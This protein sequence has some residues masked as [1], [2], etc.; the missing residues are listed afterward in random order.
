SKAVCAFSNDFPNRREPG[1]LLI[2]IHDDGTPSGLTVSDRLLQTLGALRS[3]GNIQPLPAMSVEKVALS[4]G[5]VAV[6]K[7]FPSDMPPVRYKGTVWIRAGPRRAVA[8]EAEERILS[9][10]RVVTLVH[11]DARP[12]HGSSLTDLSMDLFKLNYL[13]NA[14]DKEVIAENNRDMEEQLASLRFYDLK[15]NCPANAG[16]LLFA[17]DP[18]W[19]LPGAYIQFIRF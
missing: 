10:R 7:V 5:E 9:E 2:G 4:Q 14:V 19:W 18:V 16:M 17:K 13:P 6:I 8:S 3:D 15:K 11:F 1:Y 12:C